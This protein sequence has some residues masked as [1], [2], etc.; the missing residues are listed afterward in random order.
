VT[1]A[2]CAA[3]VRFAAAGHSRRRRSDDR[4]LRAGAGGLFH[5][6][7]G[8]CGSSSPICYPPVGF[9]VGD[10]DVLGEIAGAPF[11]S[12]SAVRILKH[13]ADHRRMTVAA[14]CFAGGWRGVRFLTR[15]WL[16]RDMK[17]MQLLVDASAHLLT[18]I[19]THL[20]K[21]RLFVG[22]AISSIRSIH[23]L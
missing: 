15:S 3:H 17:S 23:N 2:Q 1:V 22:I 5:Q 14:A 21:Q 6:S 11:I 8:Y 9:I 12:V 16:F 18:L 19:L 10:R 4:R 13:A 20:D 7:G